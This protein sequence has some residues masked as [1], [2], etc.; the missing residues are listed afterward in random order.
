M[1]VYSIPGHEISQGLTETL[2][3][4]G[5]ETVIAL[6][7]GLAGSE[8]PLPGP[9]LYSGPDDLRFQNLRRHMEVEWIDMMC[10]R[11]EICRD[12]LPLLWDADFLLGQ[13]SADTA[14]QYVLREINVSSVSPFPESAIKPLV[15][16]T[17]RALTS[18]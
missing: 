6:S 2:L 1:V 3:V 10:E 4:M 14:E 12:A 13:R 5:V 17:C 18:Q 9:R 11:L 8:A 15:E 16:V 7:P